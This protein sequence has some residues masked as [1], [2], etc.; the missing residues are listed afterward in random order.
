[1]TLHDVG[2]VVARLAVI[3]LASG[4]AVQIVK[5]LL[6]ALLRWRGRFPAEGTPGRDTW[7]D[8]IRTLAVV[9]GALFG[10]LD[11]WPLWDRW[12]FAY[13][14]ILGLVAGMSSAALYDTWFRLLRGAPDTLLDTF[15]ARFGGARA[16]RRSGRSLRRQPNPVDTRPDGLRA[17]PGDDE[18]PRDH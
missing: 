5:F 18:P 13:G 2:E 11:V 14:P 15:R 6:R 8:G 7:R 4:A 17:V 16:G 12:Q 9:V 1:M 3:G 10:C